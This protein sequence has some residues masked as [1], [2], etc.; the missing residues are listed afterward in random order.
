M[1]CPLLFS[2]THTGGP[3]DPEALVGKGADLLPGEGG[4]SIR[5]SSPGW[6][7]WP[8]RQISFPEVQKPPHP[9]ED[10]GG[11][12]CWGWKQRISLATSEGRAS[13]EMS[14]SRAEA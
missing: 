1:H 13:W 7:E 11:H 2:L 4:P 14:G 12:T 10:L 5:K 3:K 9:R 8:L 6:G